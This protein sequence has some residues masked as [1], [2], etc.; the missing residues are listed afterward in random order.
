MQSKQL[1]R[2]TIYRRNTTGLRPFCFP[3]EWFGN[4]QKQDPAMYKRISDKLDSVPT[5]LCWVYGPYV[6]FPPPADFLPPQSPKPEQSVDEWGTTWKKIHQ[7]DFPLKDLSKLA[8]YK[9]PEIIDGDG[10]FDKTLV[11]MK[12]YSDSYI[13]FFYGFCLFERYTSL[14]G[15]EN[16]LMD[17][18]VNPDEHKAIIE[19]I[20]KVNMKVLERMAQLPIDGILFGDDLGTQESMIMAP[21]MWRKL[22]KPHMKKLFDYVHEN[23]MEV[24]L[25]SDGN[26]NPI[27]EDLIEIGLNVLN[28]VQPQLFDVAELG[29][30]CGDRLSFLGGIDV[31]HYLPNG[32]KEEMLEQYN[33]Y[34]EHLSSD[35][36]GFIPNE[37]NQVL[38]DSK[39][40]NVEVVVDLMVKNR[41]EI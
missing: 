35:T 31:Q 41:M 23:D 10:R 39:L 18:Y 19:G 4:L 21:D 33:L 5:D 17:P 24:W 7:V 3:K 15:F 29:K 32:T 28:P 36:G 25:H 2:D 30:K 8:D 22:Y 12:E 27:V 1:V 38:D 20:M 11:R 40:E 26:I 13:L 14:R 6:T 16:H 9:F 37:T 34:Y